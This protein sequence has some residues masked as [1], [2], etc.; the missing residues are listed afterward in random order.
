MGTLEFTLTV[1]LA[2]D[3]DAWIA[4]YG[5]DADA[6]A[7]DVRSYVATALDDTYAANER[8]VTATVKP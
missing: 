8:L 7:E 2:V 3:A 5:I 6:V 4:E 1:T